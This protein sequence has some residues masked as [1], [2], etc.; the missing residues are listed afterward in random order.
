MNSRITWRYVYF[1]PWGSTVGYNLGIYDFLEYESDT[2]GKDGEAKFLTALIVFIARSKTWMSKLK[3]VI[4][5]YIRKS[6]KDVV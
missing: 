1:Y 5:S 2:S 4:W 6:K 3:S